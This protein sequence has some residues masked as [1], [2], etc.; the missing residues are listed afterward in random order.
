[1]LAL[2]HLNLKHQQLE[3]TDSLLNL[4]HEIT[5]EEI[6]YLRGLYDDEVMDCVDLID[7]IPIMNKYVPKMEISSDKAREDYYSEIEKSETQREAS[8][9]TGKSETR[10]ETENEFVFQHLCLLIPRMNYE[11]DELGKRK[12][13]EY[14]RDQMGRNCGI[15]YLETVEVILDVLYVLYGSYSSFET[16]DGLNSLL[17]GLKTESME[18]EENLDR[19]FLQLEEIELEK[20]KAVEKEDFL[21]ARDL[22]IEENLIQGK[23]NGQNKSRSDN[24]LWKCVRCL[25][26]IRKQLK[27][28]EIWNKREGERDREKERIVLSLLKNPNHEIRKLAVECFSLISTSST[29]TGNSS[30]FEEPN[31]HILFFKTLVFDLKTESIEIRLIGL[32]TLIDFC[33][34][35]PSVYSS[36]IQDI[37]DLY[38]RLPHKS[39]NPSMIFDSDSEDD[40]EDGDFED[41]EGIGR[42]RQ[43]MGILNEWKKEIIKGICSFY[44][45]IDS[46]TNVELLLDLF[47]NYYDKDE[48]DM[49]EIKQILNLFWDLMRR[50]R[51]YLVD[52]MCLDLLREIDV[53]NNQLVMYLIDLNNNKQM[54]VLLSLSL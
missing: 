3:L 21:L 6:V 23:I 41:M 42:D 15:Q 35:S 48:E 17:F 36:I 33:L 24:S 5:N 18:I 1:L 47:L 39:H 34:C 12:M 32:K 40:L 14:L 22:K 19:Y 37:V 16:R 28:D 43:D 50:K 46:F 11:M 2:K 26:I 53:E 13:I 31:P 27:T 30:S 29:V 54:M 52:R 8:S 49:V 45:F 10:R 20:I 9:E 4:S 25:C 51:S 38:R 44:L 7:F